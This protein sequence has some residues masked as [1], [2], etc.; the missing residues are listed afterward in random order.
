MNVLFVTVEAYPFQKVGGLG[1]VSYSLS[2]ALNSLGVKVN[3]IM[4]KYRC[5]KKLKKRMKFINRFKTFIGWKMVECQLWCAKYENITYYF[6]D[7][8]YYFYRDNVYGYVDDNEKYIFFSKAVLEGLKYLD[9]FKVDILH[10]NDWHSALVIP[11]KNIYYKG[12]KYYEGIKTVFTIHNLCYQGLYDKKSTFWMLGIDE[13]KY[14]VEDKFKFNN[15]VSFIKWGI[16]EADKITTVS[17]QYSKEIRTYEHGCGLEKMLIKRECDLIGIENGI[18]ITLF[19]PKDDKKIYINYSKDT[20]SNKSINKKHFKKEFGIFEGD[21]PLLGM[22]SRLVDQKGID[23]IINNMQEIIDKGIQLVIL[24]SGELEI[25]EKLK[26]L[27]QKFR[28]NLKVFIKYDDDLAHKIYAA[29]DFFLMPSKYEPCGTSQLI[30]MRY[31]TMP[32][33]RYVGGLAD[34]VSSLNKETLTGTGIIFNKYSKLGIL[35][36][37]DN[38]IKIFYDNN[39]KEVMIKNCMQFCSDW[40]QSA[41][42]YKELY[43]S[44]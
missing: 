6:I 38:A 31:G 5:N 43:K 20:V 7:N 36:A 30:A 24:G 2:K 32:I 11:L 41:L 3:I 12:N 10:C 13:K 42:K 8:P 27:E 39:I 9:D 17:T 1:D 35:N 34:T 28:G 4:P 44:I 37:I 15:G 25:E 19:D 29:S 16:S 40:K 26:C 23:L 21:M 18:D 33:V 22:V 14:Y